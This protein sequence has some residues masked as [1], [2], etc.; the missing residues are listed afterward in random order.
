MQSK[1]E[2]LEVV[3]EGAFGIVMKCRNKET[4]EIVAIKKFKG[5]EEEIVQKSMIRELQA[6]KRLKHE[7]IV[8]LK[9][10]F[11]KKNQ[12]YLAIEFL[13]KNLLKLLED[14]KNGLDQCLIMKI[15]FQLAKALIYMHNNDF[16]HRDI[17]PENILL[18]ED[19]NV[20]LCDF[21]FARA[22]P[23]KNGSVLTDY[24]ATRWY[25]A[26]ELLLGE[27]AYGKEMDYWAM[28]CIMGELIDGRP[29]FPGDD[30]LTQLN[31][32]QRVLGNFPRYLLEIFYSNPRF[33]GNQLEDV[34]KPET[35]KRRYMGSLAKTGIHFLKSL[36]KLDPKERLSGND[37][38]NHPYF[39]DIREECEGK[40]NK[41]DD[42]LTKKGNGT[43]KNITTQIKPILKKKKEKE[44]KPKG[45]KE[46]CF[47]K[48]KKI[49]AM[50]TKSPP[51]DITQ[52][53]LNIINQ[54]TLMGN[55][56][57]SNT[58]RKNNIN[59]CQ[60]NNSILCNENNQ[61]ANQQ[62]LETFY[63]PKTKNAQYNFGIDTHFEF[64]SNPKDKRHNK[65]IGS[66]NHYNGNGFNHNHN[67]SNCNNN[68][69]TN[70][71]TI[72]NIQNEPKIQN[73]FTKLFKP[74]HQDETLNQNQHQ[75]NEYKFNF[76]FL[77]QI[78][79]IFNNN[80]NRR[81]EENNFSNQ[82]Y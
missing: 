24:V 17:K 2:V 27:A 41:E 43:N 67:Y 20:K 40:R 61:T 73:K 28:G 9:D 36:L 48:I 79:P 4:N 6:L 15:M 12:L 7:N 1:Y 10:C 31:V 50:I 64:N 55:Q 52:K 8:Q 14:N 33:S 82:N 44:Q 13:P 66:P 70:N 19:N 69:A 76:N 23:S 25:R 45:D 63:H 39:D 34:S 75:C 16:I 5:I 29:L 42:E 77:P 56:L 81:K 11:K 35:I 18:S 65:H 60:N 32:I 26:P 37:I 74:F 57:Q 46:T 21:G 30:E 3:G 62:L 47:T 80:N 68:G 58:Q 38:I 49:R 54:N 71:N 72:C 59:M 22:L 53:R 51:K 78:N